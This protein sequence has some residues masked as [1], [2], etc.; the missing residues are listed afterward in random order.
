MRAYLNMKQRCHAALQGSHLKVFGLREEHRVSLRL[1]YMIDQEFRERN[2]HHT[3][4][5][6]VPSPVKP[7]FSLPTSTLLC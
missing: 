6:G 1:F 5:L 4:V 7:F 3:R 2:S